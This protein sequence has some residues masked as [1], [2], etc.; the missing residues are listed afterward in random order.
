MCGIAA[1]LSPNVPERQD[2]IRRVL[3]RI[4]NRGEADLQMEIDEFAHG[5]LGCNRLAVMSQ[6]HA[7]QPIRSRDGT[8]MLVYNGEVYNHRALASTESTSGTL[9]HHGD[10]AAI[11]S[12]L[13][14]GVGPSLGELDGMFA[15]VWHDFRT[16]YVYLA[17][18]RYGIKPLYYAQTNDAV[19]VASELKALAPEPTIRE[20][21][22]VQPGHLYT[23]APKKQGEFQITESRFASFLVDYQA[24]PLT[25]PALRDAIEHA[26]EACCD[27]QHRLGVYLSGGI[28]SSAVFSAASRLGCRPV[29]LIL[30]G[31][32]GVDSP[33]AVAL[34]EDLG[35]DLIKS[36]VPEETELFE[37]LDETIRIVESFEPNVVRQ[38]SVQFFISQLARQA[39]VKVVLCGEGADEL[40]CGY[41]EFT[42]TEDDWITTRNAF[43]G[44]L[45]RTQLQRVDRM[46]M[47][48]TTE[49]RVPYLCKRVSDLALASRDKADFVGYSGSRPIVKMCLRNA[50]AGV[51]PDRW[52][53]R[54]KVV[55]SEG[56]GLGGNDP[57]TGMFAK[58]AASRITADELNEIQ[59]SFPEW[60]IGSREEALYFLRF[61]SLGYSKAH[62]LRRRVTANRIHSY[63]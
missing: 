45:Y 52:R 48:F 40:F 55:L 41:P 35:E 50:L 36:N 20:V 1:Y 38:S 62:S 14:R 19:F 15:L 16:G 3:A 53:L 58:L 17:R 25:L 49:V 10:A 13:A 6:R 28:D 11:L 39:G 32:G 46:S 57:L 37:R 60:R 47:H 63:I 44:D 42:K 9:A 31:R 51:I 12:T 26:V 24:A 54:P 27:C 59:M 8:L 43:L 22:E 2:V 4:S 23:I 34:A 18:D 30:S 7:K 33:H 56:V 29:A 21:R 61:H 5:A